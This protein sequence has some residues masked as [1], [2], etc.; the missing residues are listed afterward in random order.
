MEIENILKKSCNFCIVYRE[1]RKR[2]SDNSTSIGLLQRFCHE[3]PSVCSKFKIIILGRGQTIFSTLY[4]QSE[5]K[6]YF[7][8]SYVMNMRDDLVFAF[9]ASWKAESIVME[10]SWNFIIR[11][12]ID[13]LILFQY[14]IEA[15]VAWWIRCWM[16]RLPAQEK[17]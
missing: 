16:Q 2:S 12:L 1:S 17:H 8:F 4:F 13:N 15:A 9:L 10:K 14:H 6:C 3:M 11:F 5:N 7:L